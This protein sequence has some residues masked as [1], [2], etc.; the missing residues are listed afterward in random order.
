MLVI[1]GV[2]SRLLEEHLEHA[3]PTGERSVPRYKQVQQRA[4]GGY[5]HGSSGDDIGLDFIR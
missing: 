1:T 5:G 2:K 4:E 3:P